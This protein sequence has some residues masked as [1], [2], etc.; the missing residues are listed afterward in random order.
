[1]IIIMF[2]VSLPLLSEKKMLYSKYIIGLT[3]VL[4]LCFLGACADD[5]SNKN[6][7]L[8]NVGKTVYMQQC[9]ACHGVQGNAQ[10]G[11]AANLT[12]TVLPLSEVENIVKN[13][14]GVMV[15]YKNIL[16]EA[17][18]QAVSIYV[19]GLRHTTK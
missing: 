13:G 4:A 11:G 5:G 3:G 18:I 10:L 7:A 16:S 15:P 8:S 14:K 9:M 2:K 1:M 6:E 19:M 12:Q 17:Q